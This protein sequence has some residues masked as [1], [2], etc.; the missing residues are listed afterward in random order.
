MKISNEIEVR[1]GDDGLITLR[2]PTNKEWNDFTAS[3]YPTKGRK[4]KDKSTPA[5][6]DLFDKVVTKI[7]KI[8]DDTGPITVETKERLPNRIKSSAI[9]QAFEDEDVEEAEGKN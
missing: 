8:E 9:F 7:E 5:R 2:E 3:R 4:T 6:A 1:V